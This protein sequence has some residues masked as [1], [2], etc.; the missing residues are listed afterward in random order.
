M[1]GIA[2]AIVGSA[3]IG[4]VMSSNAQ[5]DAANTAA[6]AQTAASQASIAE[7]RRQFDAIQALLSPY[8]GAGTGALSAQQDLLGLNGAGKQQSA[9]SS[10]LASPEFS[11]MT[12]QGE[13]AILANASATGNLRGGNTQ[14]ALAQFRPQVL[15]QLISD[16]Y[17]KLGGLTSLGQ[18]AA[19]G[20][21][22]A[23]M[24]TGSQ[25]AGLLQQIGSAQAGAAL[26]GGRA[27][28]GMWNNIAGSV[29]LVAAMKGFGGIGA[30]AGTPSGAV[31]GYGLQVPAGF[32]WGGF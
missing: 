4:G 6:G 14:A 23:G 3:V 30:G 11:A 16:R 7:T 9:I 5:Q 18:N 22:N 12:Q 15:A 1:S 28:A 10:I 25:V 27:D 20:V 8:V 31:G 29:G 24:Q 17:S 13:N 2:T 21:G 32:S 19:A 26:A